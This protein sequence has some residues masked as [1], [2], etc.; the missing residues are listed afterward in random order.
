MNR[1]AVSEW[2]KGPHWKCGVPQKGTEG[3]NPSCSDDRTN[4]PAVCAA[5]VPLLDSGEPM[6]RHARWLALAVSCATVMQVPGCLRDVARIFAA[7]FL[8]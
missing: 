7:T 6:R 4:A 5:R 8:I 3:S 1:G 2:L